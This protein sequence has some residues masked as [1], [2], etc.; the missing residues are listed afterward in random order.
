[1][2]EL[3]LT[4]KGSQDKSNDWREEM[5]YSSEPQTDFFLMKPSHKSQI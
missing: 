5:F 3:V 1:M 2:V 4:T